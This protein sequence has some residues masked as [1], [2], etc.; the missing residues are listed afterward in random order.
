[1]RKKKSVGAKAPRTKAKK[2][3]N[4]DVCSVS[5][6]KRAS[7][8]T[9]E[10]KPLCQKHWEAQCKSDESAPKKAEKAERKPSLLSKA[11]EVLSKATEPMNIRQLLA[12][13]DWTTP[14]GGLTPGATL[15]AAI[16][17][18]I[19]KAAHPRFKKVG[20]GLFAAAS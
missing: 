4:A 20:H 10:G 16:Q 18:E 2:T 13:V 19:A 9:F 3:K 5:R 7:E 15:S 1:M 17:R 12:A 6:C 14:K 8:L 11:A